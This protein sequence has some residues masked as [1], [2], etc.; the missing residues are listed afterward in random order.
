MTNAD[1]ETGR[2]WHGVKVGDVTAEQARKALDN[3]IHRRNRMS[4]PVRGD[5]DDIVLSAFIDQH[6]RLLPDSEHELRNLLAIIHRDGGHYYAEHGAK[7]AV[8]DAHL[9]WAELQKQ[10][11]LLPEALAALVG[12][13]GWCVAKH[14]LHGTLVGLHRVSCDRRPCN[15]EQVQAGEHWHMEPCKLQDHERTLIARLQAATGGA[16]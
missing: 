10:V 13:C 6:A 11:D 2:E 14:P 4:V 8:E 16:P 9:V 15:R 7:K 5:D 3:F 1:G 12:R